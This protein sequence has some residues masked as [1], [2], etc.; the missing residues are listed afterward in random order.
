M[1]T[2]DSERLETLWTEIKLLEA[3][4]IEYGADQINWRLLEIARICIHW[5]EIKKVLV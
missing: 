4:G 5:I 3:R 2:E 1:D